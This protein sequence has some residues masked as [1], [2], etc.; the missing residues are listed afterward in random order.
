MPACWF[1]DDTENATNV[2]IDATD[3]SCNNC[4]PQNISIKEELSLSSV[5][6]DDVG[7]SINLQKKST[8]M[9]HKGKRTHLLNFESWCAV[10][11]HCYYYC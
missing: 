11:A 2:G 6:E 1:T 4:A 3:N 10:D 8:G 9:M 7:P 5:S